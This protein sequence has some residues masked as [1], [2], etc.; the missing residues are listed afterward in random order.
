MALVEDGDEDKKQESTTET[1]DVDIDVDVNNISGSACK[2]R[3]QV[4]I[5]SEEC[6]HAHEIKETEA[7]N[8]SHH[9]NKGMP[10]TPSMEDIRL[11]YVMP[12]S[13]FSN[14]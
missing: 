2:G 6:N 5:D 13:S 1:V 8:S 4:R 3:A 14:R 11:R 7:I 10:K 12:T 9:E